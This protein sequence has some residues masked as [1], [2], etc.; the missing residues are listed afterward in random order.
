MIK[1]EIKGLDVG[2]Y[3]EKLDNGLQIYMIPFEN[4]NNYSIEY[5]TKY[6]SYT[7][8]FKSN[9]TG[10]KIKT[11]PGVAH[12]LEHKMFEQEDGISPFNYYSQ[13]GTEA[14]ASTG[15]RVTSY[16]VDGTTNIEENLEYLL[17]YVNSPHF[18]D[19][20]VEKEKGIIIEELNMYKDEPENRLYEE[21]NKILF[22]KHPLRID[23]GG[24]PKSVNKITKEILY[25]CY[26]T[27]YQPSNMVLLISGK[28]DPKK[29][30]KVVK[31][32]KKLNSKESNKEI[33]IYKENEPYNVRLK[34]KEIKIES[35]V[36]PK[37]IYT[38]KLR[39]P[40]LEG[41]EKYKFKVILEIFLY[42]LYGMS[43]E[44]REEMLNKDMFS[45][46]FTSGILLDDF[47]LIE[48][49]S[50]TK[51]PKEFKKAIEKSLMTIKITK[52]DVERVKK[53]KLSIEVVESD[54][55]YQ[56][57]NASLSEI[58]DYGDIIYNKVDII[59][60]I[61]LEDVLKI[62]DYIDISNSSLM[63]G[64]PKE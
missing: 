39:R 8:S 41:E 64:Y 46:F 42:C 4:R 21:S 7:N 63:I 5:L 3:Y 38:L 12:F 33:T 43:S 24:T 56:L 48:F 28:F 35:M 15:Y 60:S 6:G 62:R 18:T 47:M 14:N 50:E 25:E 58:L 54:K 36:I 17:N 20:N 61:T 29:I 27:F 49:I 32:N 26:S 1:K 31:S 13:T 59:K 34:E 16:S 55:P 19:K 23:V 2:V 10:K 45:L 30:L 52:K 37:F 44:F 9:I 40:K 51:Y 57:L 11:P 22:Y 53:V